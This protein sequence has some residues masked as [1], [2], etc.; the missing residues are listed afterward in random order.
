MGHLLGAGVEGGLGRRVGAGGAAGGAPIHVGSL[1]GDCARPHL[2]GGGI[3]VR[4]LPLLTSPRTPAHTAQHLWCSAA[5]TSWH[6]CVQ[7]Q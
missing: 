4:W 3:T 1:V 2:Q 7:A 6:S 5:L